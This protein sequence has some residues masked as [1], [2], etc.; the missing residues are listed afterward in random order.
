MITITFNS[1]WGDKPFEFETQEAALSWLRSITDLDF[2]AE[3][4]GVTY[5]SHADAPGFDRLVCESPDL[6]TLGEV[7]ELTGLSSALIA[8][9]REALGGVYRAGTPLFARAAVEAFMARPRRA[10]RPAKTE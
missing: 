8:R 5:R 3:V 2:I 7:R 1:G 10:G 9:H 4:D 6:L